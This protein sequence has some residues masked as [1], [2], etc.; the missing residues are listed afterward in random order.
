MLK[1]DIDEKLVFDRLTQAQEHVHEALCDDFNTSRVIEE[2]FELISL[3]NKSF[4]TVEETTS[5]NE[6]QPMNRHYG[7]IM[8]VSNYVESTFSLMGIEVGSNAY[9]VNLESVLLNLNIICI[10][11]FVF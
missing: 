5:K 9:L 10:T 6:N 1:V 11:N 4:Q 2:I 3:V 8:S 7:C